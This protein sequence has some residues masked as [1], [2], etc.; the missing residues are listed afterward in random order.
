MKVINQFPNHHYEQQYSKVDYY[1]PGCGILGLW[2][3]DSGGDQ[4]LGLDYVCSRCG[5]KCHLD[6]SS[7]TTQQNDIG[8]LEQLRSGITS[9]PT[10]KKGN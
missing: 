5:F 4:Y 2:V 1:C 3:E 10:T 6:S 7:Q 8:I 9:V